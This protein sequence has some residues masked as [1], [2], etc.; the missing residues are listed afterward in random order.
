MGYKDQLGIAQQSDYDSQ[1]TVTRFYEWE[2]DSLAPVQ[3]NILTDIRGSQFHRTDLDRIFENGGGGDIQMDFMQKS[4][5]LWLKNIFG[6]VTVAQVGSTAEYKQ[7]HTPATN[8]TR[9]LALT[10]QK[11]VE[12]AAGVVQPFT[13]VGTKILRATFSNDLDQNL[14]LAMGT[15]FKLTNDATAL[16]VAAY[17]SNLVPLSFL[18]AN[19]NLDGDDICA[20]NVSVVIERPLNTDRRCLG[21][22]KREALQNGKLNVTGTMDLEFENRDQYDAWRA[23]T[24]SPLI[25]TWA[26]GEVE[27]DGN[28]F[29]LVLTLANIKRRGEMPTAN[30]NEIARQNVAFQALWDGTLPL[31][32]AEYHSTDTAV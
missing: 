4:M 14:K 13:F 28:P 1:A 7:T 23:G 26:Y 3:G 16:A 19:I 5:G 21:N 17:P 20:R 24:L 10:V 29:K 15:D 31:I 32:K 30:G 22:T 2:S 27:E 11:G 8:G 18:D 12:D 25:A 6:A 9:G